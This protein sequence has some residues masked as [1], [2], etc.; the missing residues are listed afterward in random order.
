MMEITRIIFH[1]FVR[2]YN[3]TQAAKELEEVALGR[4]SR[5][6]I[7]TKEELKKF[8]HVCYAKICEIYRLVRT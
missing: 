3:A 2:D 5:L 1:Y 6:N 8:K 7:L 4:F